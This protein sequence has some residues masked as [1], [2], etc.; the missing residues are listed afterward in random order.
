VALRLAGS[1]RLFSG[2]LGLGPAEEPGSV[3]HLAMQSFQA[4]QRSWWWK[5]LPVLARLLCHVC[6]KLLADIIDVELRDI[7]FVAWRLDFGGDLG[8]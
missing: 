2:Q 7:L 3:W 5:W 8:Y 6:G 4:E 1:G